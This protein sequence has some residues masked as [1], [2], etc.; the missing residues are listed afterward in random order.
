V[1][2]RERLMAQGRSPDP[3]LTMANERTFL[4]WIRT[5]LAMIAGGVGIAAFVDD[6]I[7]AWLR[8][9]VSCVLLVIG[10][11]LALGSFLRWRDAEA[12]MRRGDELTITS[13][14]PLVSSGVA[15]VAL[16]LLVAVLVRH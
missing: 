7:P 3:R 5:S 11:A 12:A 10:I 8:V 14:A 15:V 9:T 4:A 16:A 2:W 1:S 6:A 13:L